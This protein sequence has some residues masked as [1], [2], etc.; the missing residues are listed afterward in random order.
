MPEG[1]EPRASI[2]ERDIL[3]QD[4][5]SS[6]ET[7]ARLIAAPTSVGHLL[8][9]ESPMRRS[10]ATFALALAGLILL[11]CK[12][13]NP[14][15]APIPVDPAAWLY[16]TF[17]GRARCYSLDQ[18]GTPIYDWIAD[19]VRVKFAPGPVCSVSC[20]GATRAAPCWISAHADSLYFLSDSLLCTGGGD[21]VLWAAFPGRTRASDQSLSGYISDLTVD[22]GGDFDL[23]RLR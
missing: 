8:S 23:R 1:Y 7:V 2:P 19:S 20:Y 16:G 4:Q 15:T 22:K 13:S 10:E 12:G 14:P 21:Q 6:A 17:S 18:Y 9:R 3:L 5:P 11:G